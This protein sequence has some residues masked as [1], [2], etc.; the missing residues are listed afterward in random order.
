MGRQCCRAEFGTVDGRGKTRRK[1][2]GDLPPRLLL[3]LLARLCF[4]A[5]AGAPRGLGGKLL[6]VG[7][8]GFAGTHRYGPGF[9]DAILPTIRHFK[10]NNPPLQVRH[11][12]E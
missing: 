6:T 11:D 12:D 5:G 3:L 10:P 2:R 7:S 9:A 4:A 1:P 8:R